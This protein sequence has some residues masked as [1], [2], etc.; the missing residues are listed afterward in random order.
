MDLSDLSRLPDSVLWPLHR[1]GLDPV[2]E[3][4][5]HREQE[6]VSRLPLP[7]GVRAWLVTGHDE[8]KAVLS[9]VGAFSN[10]FA[11]FAGSTGIGARHDPG[12]LGFADPPVHTRLRRLLA[13]EFTMRRLRRL[14]P[15]IQA[16]VDEVLDAIEPGDAPVDLW[17]AF[18][19]PIPSLTICELLGVPYDEREQFQRLATARFDLT[20]ATG[21]SLAAISESLSYLSD[22][23]DRQRRAP[24]DGLLGMLIR[25]HGDA[26]DDRELTGLADGVL[27]GGLETTASMLA[28]GALVIAREPRLKR[29]LTDTHPDDGVIG[30]GQATA[31]FVEELL[32]YLSVVQVAF[33]RCAVRDFQLGGVRIVA[34][35]LVACSLS[36]ANRAGV[37]GADPE[38]LDPT[39]PAHPHLAFGH[40]AH[41]CIGAELARMELH[42]AYPA[43]VRR[44]PRLRLAV[45]PGQLQFRDASI[46]FGLQAL[47]VLVT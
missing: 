11:N 4:S 42:V 10:D 17:R 40:G 21:G 31:Q 35:D 25:E 7:F 46:V 27:T 26:V 41:R 5:R 37:F 6:P 13:P 29:L 45:D 32:R 8:V 19:L 23:V 3:L 20:G 30:G 12:G 15:R 33:P 22:L 9:D 38:V 36:A 18:A 14:T 39:R 47:P 2:A 28:L 44:F 24:G 16:I 34:G 1:D 43:L